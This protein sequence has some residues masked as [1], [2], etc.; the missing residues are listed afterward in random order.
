[1]I[2][3]VHTT[4]FTYAGQANN[5]F[6]EVRLRPIDDELQVCRRFTLTTTP[7]S[8]PRDYTDFYGNLVYYFDVPEAHKTLT[9]EA[10]PP[11]D[12]SARKSSSGIACF[13]DT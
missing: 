9:A 1:M 7:N 11:P 5:N 4:K 6:N 10:L 2:R 8:T 13:A 12:A 3:I